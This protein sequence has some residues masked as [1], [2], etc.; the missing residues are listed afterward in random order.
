MACPPCRACCAGAGCPGRSRWGGGGRRGHRGRAAGGRRGRAAF[1]GRAACGGRRGRAAFRGRRHHRPSGA[2]RYGQTVPCRNGRGHNRRSHAPAACP[3]RSRRSW[4][5]RNCAGRGGRS[6]G[7]RGRAG[8]NRT[9]HDR[10]GRNRTG[11]NR[12][13]RNRTGRNRTG[14]NRTGHNRTG[15]NSAGRCGRGRGCH[16]RMG[17]SPAGCGGR[18]RGCHAW[19]GLYPVAPGR[20]RPRHGRRVVTRLR[21]LEAARVTAE[22]VVTRLRLLEAARVTAGG[23]VTRWGAAA[24]VARIVAR[25][26]T[27][28]VV[29][30]FVTGPGLGR[31]RGPAELVVARRV[32]AG[33]SAGSGVMRPGRA[34]EIA[35]V[36][37][38]LMVRADV[39][40]VVRRGARGERLGRDREDHPREDCPPRAPGGPPRTRGSR[41]L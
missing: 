23:V 3:A 11:R 26:G 15:H 21:L 33:G 6:R 38:S 1:Q 17:H 4:T 16:G 19:R 29:M 28:A 34:V 2:A 10:T 35:A 27:P 25:G 14:R 24:D 12:T 32:V 5:G 39:T 13:G 40:W 31:W 9:G 7:C 37:T 8:H 22:G 41:S 36:V 20:S 18:S 30:R